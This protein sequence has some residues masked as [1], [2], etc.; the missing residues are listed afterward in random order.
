MISQRLSAVLLLISLAVTG[1]A[2]AQT[3]PFGDGWR[4][5]PGASTLQFQS[6][7]NESK[8]ETSGFATFSGEISPAGDVSLSVLLDSVDTKV[9]LRN[10]RMRF[11]FF[12]TFTFPEAKV[13]AHIDPATIADLQ[14][15]RR[16][17]VEMPFTLDLHGVTREVPAKL[18]ITLIG[19]DL[20]AVSAA[21]PIVLPVADFNLAEGLAK[22]EEAATVKIVPSGSVSFDLIFRKTG[23][24]TP[25]PV[26]AAAEASAPAPSAALETAGNFSLE[27]C[28]GRF[29]ILSRTGN[30]YFAPGSAQLDAASTPLLKQAVDIISRCPDLKVQVSGHTDNIGSAASNMRLSERRAA[31]VK[32]YL[33]AQGIE[34]GRI[35][36][37]GFGESRP[38]ADNGT[39]TGRGRNRRIEFSADGS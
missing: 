19:D 1:G 35:S 20:V 38:V 26:Q 37:V 22:L 34:A 14:T 7:K 31:A 16:K 12:E 29:E 5:E 13:T 28:L 24:G 11:L 33:A 17:T 8:I 30:I 6:I 32:G 2:Q 25:Q 39:D 18:A 4:L 27:A 36:S 10:V 15:V 9:D 3:S 21:E 23:A